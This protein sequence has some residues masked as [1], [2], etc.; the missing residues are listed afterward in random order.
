VQLLQVPPGTLAPGGYSR[1]SAVQ[2]LLL[3]MSLQPPTAVASASAAAPNH[4][5]LTQL[6][7]CIGSSQQQAACLKLGPRW[8]A[9]QSEF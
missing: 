4:P 8:R 1:P 6:L 7:A 2:P 9:A 5:I 3:K